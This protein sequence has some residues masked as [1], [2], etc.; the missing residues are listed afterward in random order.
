MPDLYSFGLEI[1]DNY[2]ANTIIA[3][4][5]ICYAIAARFHMSK[6]LI[7]K[8]KLMPQD[9]GTGWMF[10]WMLPS[11]IVNVKLANEYVVQAPI[12]Q[13]FN[14]ASR[15]YETRMKSIDDKVAQLENEYNTRND[16]NKSLAVGVQNS[17]LSMQEGLYKIAA[18]VVAQK[19]MQN[20]VY[21]I[22]KSDIKS[23][24]KALKK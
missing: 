18:A 9:I 14:D 22:V 15:D 16:K 1:E 21:K 23:A 12:V 17:L 24:A 13:K 8:N 11:D 19:Y 20:G 3:L 2:W 5:F 10:S 6:V 4:L 7:E